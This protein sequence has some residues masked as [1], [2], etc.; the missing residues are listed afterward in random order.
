MKPILRTVIGGHFV[1]PENGNLK[2]TCR[3]RN[4]AHRCCLLFLEQHATLNGLS[5]DT[6]NLN[7]GGGKLHCIDGWIGNLI[8][9]EERKAFINQVKDELVKSLNP[10]HIEEYL[11]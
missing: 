9:K 11:Y 3:L 1:C 4:P 7:G 6:L 8:P 10:S 2:E 5:M